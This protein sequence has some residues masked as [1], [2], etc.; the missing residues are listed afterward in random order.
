MPGVRN[1]LESSRCAVIASVGPLIQPVT[2]T[3]YQHKTV[4]LPPQLFSHND[5]TN[6]W[7]TLRGRQSLRSGWAGRV[8]DALAG[9]LTEQQLAAN[10]SLSGNSVFSVGEIATPYI[11]SATGAKEFTGFGST[12]TDL[13]RQR[14]F[15]RIVAS[16]YNDVY[17]RAYA[18]VQRRAVLYAK[19]V[20]DALEAAPAVLTKGF[21]AQI[22]ARDA[23][24][25]SGEDDRR[26]RSSRHV[27][28]IFFVATAAMTLT[29]ISWRISPGL[30]SDLNGR[31][32]R[33][34][35]QP[36]SPAGR[37]TS[38]PSP[39]RIPAVADV[40][41]DEAITPGAVCSW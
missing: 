11:M 7:L 10:V 9:G 14:A 5:Q 24:Q 13:Q 30:L 6:Q 21:N 35:L 29:T 38:R 27:A 3:Q 2:K 26:T 41:G 1:L 22:G 23:A 33:S 18:D 8:A 4:Q 40:K 31:C 39:S 12:G 15:E 20:N 19:Q 17:G 16:D 32:R 37:R 34:T 25:D 28:E 36:S